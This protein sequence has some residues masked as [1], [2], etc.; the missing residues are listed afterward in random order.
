MAIIKPFKAW[1]PKAEFVKA[2]SSVP[3]DV[4]NTEEAIDLA[5]GKPNSFL[6]VIRPEIDLPSDIDIHDDRVY[7]LGKINLDRLLNSDTFVQEDSEALYIYR[8]SWKELSKTGVFGC[9]SVKDYDHELILKHELTRPDKEDDRTKHIL[10][11]RAHSEPVM[12]TFQNDSVINSLISES[13]KADPI[14]DFTTDEGIQH[15]VWKAS[16]YEAL[17]LAFSDIPTLYIADGHHRCASASRVAHEIASENPSHTG[18]EHYNF[19][20]AV[21]FPQR[22]MNILAYNRVIYSLPNDF[23]QKLEAQFDVIENV[24]PSPANKGSISLYMNKKWYGIALPDSK[25]MDS[26]SKL[27][28]A[29][30]QEF[31]LEP[32]LNISNQRTD[33]NIHFVGGIRGSKELEKLVDSGEVELGISMYPTSIEEL[34][35]VSDDKLLM[36]PKTTWFEPKLR[37]GILIHTF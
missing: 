29:R 30:L 32:L 13:T 27:D 35:T 37:S 26:A 7:E 18:K 4:I 28:I 12:L 16:N 11:Q 15:T 6:H 21:L 2:V 10:T 25:K 5:E 3:Y 8:I 36:P 31:I 14:F 33:P 1:R 23:L 9:V 17:V 19:F 24:S 34:I 20:P 22:E